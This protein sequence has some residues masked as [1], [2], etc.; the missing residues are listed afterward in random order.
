MYSYCIGACTNCQICLGQGYTQTLY[1][2]SNGRGWRVHVPLPA[3]G[4][5][6]VCINW[7]LYPDHLPVELPRALA[8]LRQNVTSRKEE[9]RM[10]LN[11]G[12]WRLQKRWR[13]EWA[14]NQTVSQHSVDNLVSI[15]TWSHIVWWEEDPPARHAKVWSRKLTLAWMVVSWSY[16]HEHLWDIQP[17]IRWSLFYWLYWNRME[18]FRSRSE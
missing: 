3:I 17:S 12:S 16:M 13:Q 2:K 4:A 1:Q 18:Q 8:K 9:G 7:T 5:V 6:Q 10:V 14:P 11:G 15:I